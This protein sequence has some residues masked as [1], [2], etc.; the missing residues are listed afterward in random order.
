MNET[1][2]SQLI[3]VMG[4]YYSFAETWIICRIYYVITG[5]N[6]IIGLIIECDSMRLTDHLH[7]RVR[8]YT[9]DHP[10]QIF[11]RCIQLFSIVCTERVYLISLKYYFL[12]NECFGLFPREGVWKSE[13][14]V[15]IRFK[16]TNQFVGWI[17]IY[18]IHKTI[19]AYNKT[20]TTVKRYCSKP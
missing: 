15:F 7:H 3:T 5:V 14:K 4:V 19:Q 18:I 20:T 9:R 13:H 16:D 10:N 2:T 17:V 12:L 6:S 8:L 1:D 11:G